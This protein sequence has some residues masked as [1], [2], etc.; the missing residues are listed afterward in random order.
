MRTLARHRTPIALGA[1]FVA[2]GLI[3]WVVQAAL[4]PHRLD[5][6]GVVGLVL[7]GFAMAFTFAVLLSGNS[8]DE[9]GE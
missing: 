9:S 5:M 2:V 3:Y 7:L 4:G 1:I 6:V 8:T